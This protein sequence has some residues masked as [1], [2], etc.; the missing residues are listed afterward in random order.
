MWCLEADPARR[1]TSAQVVAK[2]LP[3][4]DPLANA[5]AA[6]ETP[7]PEM[8][9]AAGGRG[10]MRPLT[11][12]LCLAGIIIGMLVIAGLN[13]GAALFRLARL[14]K[15]PV[16]LA[17]RARR[18]LNDAGL[19]EEPGATVYR[20]GVDRAFL[21]QIQRNDSTPARWRQVREAP[22]AVYYLWYREGPSP[23]IPYDTRDA[24]VTYFDPPMHT[25]GMAYVRLSTDGRLL[26][27][28]V[29]AE[30]ESVWEGN[31]EAVDWSKLFTE[32][33]L[34]PTRLERV[35]NAGLKVTEEN[36]QGHGPGLTPRVPTDHMA[37]WVGASP[38]R[39]QDSL[40]VRAGSYQARP[41]FFSTNVTYKSASDSRA[42][43]VALGDTTG[44]EHIG[45][46]G[47]PAS[48]FGAGVAIG[49]RDTEATQTGRSVSY[50]AGM[51]VGVVIGFASLALV[52]V[53]L[54]GGPFMAWRNLR[55]G[56][57]DRRGALRFGLF[58][59]GL[60]LAN[61]L[62]VADHAILMQNNT[63]NLGYEYSILLGKL[64]MA[65]LYGAYVAL[66]Y[67]ALEPYVRRH[68]PNAL[69]SWTRL[70][71]GKL[72]DPLV[73]RDLLLGSVCGVLI[74]L[75]WLMR[76]IAPPWFGLAPP[77]PFNAE[78][79]ALKGGAGAIAAFVSPTF[80]FPSMLGVLALVVLV[81]LLRRRWLA[82]TVLVVLVIAIGALGEFQS[83]GDPAGTSLT[84]VVCLSAMVAVL[85]LLF[86]RSGLLALTV[87]F[88]FFRKIRR[89]PLTLDSSAWYAGTSTLLILALT[90]IA[91]YALS[92][93]IRGYPK[94]S[95]RGLGSN[96]PNMPPE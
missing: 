73:G 42:A 47:E 94:A 44:A 91:V 38:W 49:V 56:R 60:V 31:P 68:W 90:A 12:A 17:D 46:A 37:A 6:G 79:A 3:G 59:F 71:R 9:A 41:V 83:S 18:I 81:I 96:V 85:L 62:L 58:A 29:V 70:L 22:Y 53:V 55:M 39:S 19:E 77:C 64:G 80:L 52:L 72:G 10:G 4:G 69:I 76:H 75:L 8:V 26:A 23:L 57:G 14:D 66:A 40:K 28:E 50:D 92:A 1:P 95:G 93:A 27:L 2:A 78:L 24:K 16:V 89:F 32:A 34:E 86:V 61:N 82:L 5:L 67:L 65:I 43:G 25:P 74:A 33:G 54:V 48:G 88:F 21:R 87:A 15:P 36:R 84:T 7:S 35:G 11:A 30:P 20:L 13:N 51:I 63:V 45:E